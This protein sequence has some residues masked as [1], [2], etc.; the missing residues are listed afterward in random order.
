[1]SLSCHFHDK[2]VLK[3]QYFKNE[4]IL[5]VE[6]EEISELDENKSIFLYIKGT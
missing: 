5:H 2:I 1:M 4:K 6:N 3:I